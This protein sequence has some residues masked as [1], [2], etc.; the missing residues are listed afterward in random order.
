MR[1]PTIAVLLAATAL[2]LSSVA[3]APGASAAPSANGLGHRAT[4]VCSTAAEG[5]AACH[6][7]RED[8]VTSTGQVTAAAHPAATAAPAGLA[9]ADLRSAYAL[10]GASGAGRTVAIVDAYDAPTAEADLATYRSRYGLP[11]CTTANGCFRKVSQ[12]GSTTALPKADGGWAQEI[13]LDVDMVSAT[14]P[15]CSI[16]L[17]EVK[18]TSFTDLSAGVR[19]AA[20]QKVAAI[21]NSYG[22]GDSGN[23]TIAA[24]YN[25]PGIAVTASTGDNGYGISSPASFPTV[26]AV[27]GTSLRKDSSEIGR[28]HV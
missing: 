25:Q 21:S 13:S 27:G 12:T 10:T 11:A 18:S 3:L 6:A 19:Y 1:R 23:A 16:L 8:T 28:A 17:V 20:G 15:D 22:G 9:S 26:V 14:C 2:S 24:A 7:V 5:H 4:H